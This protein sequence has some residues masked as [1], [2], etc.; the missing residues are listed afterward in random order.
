MTDQRVSWQAVGRDE[1]LSRYDLR[2]RPDTT[3]YALA[4]DGRPVDHGPWSL[5]AV[6]REDESSPVA[7]LTVGTLDDEVLAGDGR[8]WERGPAYLLLDH[9]GVTALVD[10][11]GNL[12]AGLSPGAAVG[13]SLV[14]VDD[15][16]DP[17][18]DRVSRYRQDTDPTGASDRALVTITAAGPLPAPWLSL[19]LDRIPAD[20][21]AP[22]EATPAAATPLHVDR[23]DLDALAA[24]VTA[25]LRF[26]AA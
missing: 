24:V 11:L 6:T 17:S 10:L 23:D 9:R 7:T 21:V 26:L 2:L 15:A 8:S 3:L 20:A 22:G 19:G 12:A 25:E 1:A 13:S 14:R 4:E 18:G 5:V 16:A